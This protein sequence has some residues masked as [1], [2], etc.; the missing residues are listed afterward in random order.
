MKKREQ[1]KLMLI[2]KKE[3]LNF[4]NRIMNIFKERTGFTFSKKGIIDFK[5]WIGIYGI[6]EIIECFE[7]SL[8][9]YL[10]KENQDTY[11]KAI[12]YVPKI[13]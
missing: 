8:N 7:I 11:E 12:L 4:E 13:E 2:G 10:I 6:I 5:K 9:Q 1:L 3:L